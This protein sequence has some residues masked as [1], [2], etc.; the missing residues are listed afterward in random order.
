[1]DYAKIPQD[2]LLVI[3]DVVLNRR[4]GAAEDLIEMATAIK[5]KA[6]AAKAAAKAGGWHPRNL[7]L[8]N[9]ARTRWKA[10]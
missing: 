5:E 7:P 8:R 4:K 2:Q 9:G 3:E 10:D 6:D 1:M